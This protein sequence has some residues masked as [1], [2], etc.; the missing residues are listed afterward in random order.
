MAHSPPAVDVVRALRQRFSAGQTL[1]HDE[2]GAL[3]DAFDDMHDAPALPALI[4]LSS[5]ACVALT[6]THDAVLEA[7]KR[8]GLHL[9][10]VTA[11]EDHAL[12]WVWFYRWDGGTKQGPFGTLD[13]AV[14]AAIIQIRS[15]AFKNA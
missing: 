15:G 3:F 11:P 5:D 10:Q 2:I 7:L 1:S 9:Q 13:A 6:S 12:P 14:V 4:Q 8:V